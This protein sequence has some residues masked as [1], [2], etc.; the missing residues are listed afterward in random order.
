MK[1]QRTIAKILYNGI[2]KHMP[3]SDGTLSFGAKKFR[4]FCARQVLPYCGKN[5]NI[6]QHARFAWDLSIGDNSGVGINALIG[7][8]VTIGKDVMMGPDCMI[9]TTNHGMLRT[10]IPMWQQESSPPAAVIIGND[11]WIGAR[12]IILPGV[13]IGDGS[14]IGAGSVVTKDVAPYS[15]VAGNPARLIRMRESP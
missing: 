14:V 8:N 4:R 9:F 10:N 2:A 12:V 15:I 7:P 1:L 6:E 3:L 5:V 11:V 13:H